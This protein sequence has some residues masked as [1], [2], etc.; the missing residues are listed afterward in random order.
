MATKD[1]VETKELEKEKTDVSENGSA[2]FTFSKDQEVSQGDQENTE[3]EQG[4]AKPKSKVDMNDPD[5][6][7]FIEETAK[8]LAQSMN[9]KKYT[10][11]LKEFEEK[12]KA[13]DSEVEN[14][15]KQQEAETKKI[16]EQAQFT[17][18]LEA[19]R[20]KLESNGVPDNVIED[21]IARERKLYDRSQKLEAEASRFYQ[22]REAVEQKALKFDLMEGIAEEYPELPYGEAMKLA[23]EIME[24]A[25]DKSK[26]GLRY[27]LLKH[28]SK[29]GTK[30]ANR[31][32]DPAKIATAQSDGNGKSFTAKQISDMSDVEYA[33]NRD[34]IWEAQRKGLIK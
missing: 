11:K 4:E 21:T 18:Y 3:G 33:K 29:P 30:P 9:D 5:V 8:K 6:K 34:A 16:Q 1:G 27:A 12:L 17:A 19:A 32:V 25:Q 14:F 15:K 28:Q 26:Y 7:S 2:E 23:G 13:K 24:T 10:G 22:D 31:K 20:R